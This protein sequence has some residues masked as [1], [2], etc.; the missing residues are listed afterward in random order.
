ML[1]CLM[2]AATLCLA[3][4]GAD[5]ITSST[6]SS[7]IRTAERSALINSPRVVQ[8][9]GQ[10][11]DGSSAEALAA[12]ISVPGE[13]SSRPFTAAP[14]ES[15]SGIRIV[16]AYGAAAAQLCLEPRGATIDLPMVLT[17]SYCSDQSQVSTATLR[18]ET[19]V[20]PSD[21]AFARAIDRLMMAL[22]AVERRRAFGND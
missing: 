5:R 11:P 13:G 14:T 9:V 16:A 10:P 15:R 7:G 20:G 18:S 17:M 12:L 21:P 2:V 6:F 8:V 19:L 1:R 3:G 4:C 22:T